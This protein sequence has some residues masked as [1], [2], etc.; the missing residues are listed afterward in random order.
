MVESWELAISHAQGEFVT[1]IGD[2]DAVVAE[3]LDR[4][5]LLLNSYEAVAWFKTAYWWSSF[6]KACNALWFTASEYEQAYAGKESLEYLLRTF[7][8]FLFYPS[9]YNSFVRKHVIAKIRMSHGGKLYPAGAIAPDVYSSL[10]VMATV[11]NYCL[12]SSPFSLGGISRFSGGS[13]VKREEQR[14]LK[15][16]GAKEL[17]EL[18]MDNRFPYHSHERLGLLSDYLLFLSKAD[19]LHG[20]ALTKCMVG[21][22]VSKNKEQLPRWVVR[23]LMANFELNSAEVVTDDDGGFGGYLP[24]H[25]TVQVDCKH[26]G[27]TDICKAAEVYGQLLKGLPLVCIEPK[28]VRNKYWYGAMIRKI[29]VLGKIWAELRNLMKKEQ[30][31]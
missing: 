19:T 13:G 5:D 22:F 21:S 15:E 25:K 7:G 1:V 10:D 28:V 11:D 27:I 3:V 17:Y 20:D 6:T 30:R 12:I 8:N 31:S 4:V 29:P 9:F 18:Y 14:Y 24:A 2:D 26:Y 23:E 16:R